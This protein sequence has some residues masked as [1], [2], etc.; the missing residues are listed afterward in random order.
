MLCTQRDD[1]C[2]AQP[3]HRNAR[4]Y[5]NI[6]NF[7]RMVAKRILWLLW[8]GEGFDPAKL[9]RTH[10]SGR[11]RRSDCEKDTI[12]SDVFNNIA[13][14]WIIW[15]ILAGCWLQKVSRTSRIR[16]QDELSDLSLFCSQSD[17]MQSRLSLPM[18]FNDVNMDTTYNCAPVGHWTQLPKR[19]WECWH[20]LNERLEP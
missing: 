12:P 11:T 18:C 10:M 17:N 15:I 14:E 8:L 7:Q 19:L 1:G 16:S 4:K 5:C 20:L 13:L 3:G 2:Y 6:R 9:L